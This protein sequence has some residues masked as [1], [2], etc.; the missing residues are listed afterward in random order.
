[1]IDYQAEWPRVLKRIADLE[2][3]IKILAEH[4]HEYHLKIETNHG[5]NWTNSRTE[6]P[7]YSGK[8]TEW[9]VWNDASVCK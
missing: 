6:K 9:E 2:L 7:D 5:V 1:M 3:Q 8:L 4:K